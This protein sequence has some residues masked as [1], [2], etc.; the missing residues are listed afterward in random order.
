MALDRSVYQF[1]RWVEELRRAEAAVSGSRTPEHAEVVNRILGWN[2]V[3]EPDSQGALAY[4]RWREALRGLV[5]PT[6]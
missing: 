1:D 5:G 6:R 2:G 3:S 4:Y